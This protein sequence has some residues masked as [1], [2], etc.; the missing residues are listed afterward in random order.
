MRRHGADVPL[1]QGDP[2]AVWNPKQDKGTWETEKKDD[3]GVSGV[4][5]GRDGKFIV[6]RFGSR[7]QVVDERFAKINLELLSWPI[8]HVAV[9]VRAP[10][11]LANVKVV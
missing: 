5:T 8:D 6:V 9:P 3:P 1:R 10:L 4:C 2:V 11:A 7:Y